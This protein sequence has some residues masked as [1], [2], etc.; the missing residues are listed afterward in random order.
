MAAGLRLDVHILSRMGDEALSLQKVREL[1][2]RHGAL[3]YRRCLKL[4]GNP[5]DAEEA[6]Q[7]VFVRVLRGAEG[8]DY[9]SEPTTWLYRITTNYCLTLLRDQTRRRRLRER[10][11]SQPEPV[12]NGTEDA[13][14]VRHLLSEVDEPLARVAVYVYVDGMSHREAAEL[15]GVS[16]RTVGNMLERFS[17]AVKGSREMPRVADADKAEVA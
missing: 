8:F 16:R 5:S 12:A 7:E 10:H 11:A 3:V 15:L 4:L 6:L 1:F 9:R 2:Q 13:I 17:A 14:W